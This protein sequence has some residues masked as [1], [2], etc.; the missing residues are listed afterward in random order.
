M[1][2]LLRRLLTGLSLGGGGFLFLSGLLPLARTLATLQP[3]EIEL[4]P[5][6]LKLLT[7]LPLLSGSLLLLRRGRSNGNGS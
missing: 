3:L 6:V 5:A 4:L 2:P 7:G 1:S